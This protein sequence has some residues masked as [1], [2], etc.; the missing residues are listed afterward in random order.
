MKKNPWS[1]AHIILGYEQARGVHSTYPT[2]PFLRLRVRPGGTSTHSIRQIV[3]W[4]I[5]TYK[6]RVLRWPSSVSCIND[7]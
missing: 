5:Q 7:S 2:Q 4:H 1:N 3:N 6:L